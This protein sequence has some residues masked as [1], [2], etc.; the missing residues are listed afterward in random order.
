[1]TERQKADRD[2]E[3]DKQM[4]TQSEKKRDNHVLAIILQEKQR[5]SGNGKATHYVV[6]IVN[7]VVRGKDSRT[8][9][10]AKIVEWEDGLAKMISQH[11]TTCHR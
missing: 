8:N 11:A 7:L 10:H 1:M 4:E 9:S 2:R 6:G 3:T 5:L